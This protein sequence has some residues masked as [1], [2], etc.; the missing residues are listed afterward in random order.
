MGHGSTR[1]APPSW[2]GPSK[3]AAALH[4]V[5]M[6]TQSYFYL[7]Y[8]IKYLICDSTIGRWNGCALEIYYT[9]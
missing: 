7:E 6:L 9:K 3:P 5:S 1:Q 4:A 2:E 8:I